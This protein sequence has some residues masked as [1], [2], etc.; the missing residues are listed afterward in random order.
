MNNNYWEES[1]RKAYAV[2]DEDAIISRIKECEFV[3]DKIETDELWKLILRDIAEWTTTL[4]SK[5]QEAYADQLEQ[6]RVVKQACVHLQ[7]LKDGYITDLKFAKEELARR[8]DPMT[9]ERDM[10]N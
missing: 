8:G 2:S 10:E 4:D 5:W 9:I 3:V 7:N 6:M 1:K